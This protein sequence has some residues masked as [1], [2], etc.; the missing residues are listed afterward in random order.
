LQ[1][2]RTR[3]LRAELE[4]VLRGEWAHLVGSSV[5][6]VLAAALRALQGSESFEEG[7][8]RAV[9]AARQRATCGA[10]YGALAGAL[11]GVEQIPA[12]WRAR[13]PQQAALLRV[14]QRCA[15]Q[16]VEPQS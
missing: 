14:A 16:A 5:P 2:V 15:A 7:M 3:K 1:A 9:S 8:V 6:A 10:L 11:H 13:L 4:P 12:Q